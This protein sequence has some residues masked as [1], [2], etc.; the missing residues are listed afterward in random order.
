LSLQGVYRLSSALEV[1]EKRLKRVYPRRIVVTRF[2]SRRRLAFE[3][4]RQLR[5]RYGE[6]VCKTRIAE[7][8][9]LATSPSVGQDVFRYAPHSGG[10]ADYA[11]LAEALSEAGFLRVSRK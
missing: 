8:V 9:A 11:A 2:N 7:N 5:E 6:D 3:V 10:A 4:D 1:L